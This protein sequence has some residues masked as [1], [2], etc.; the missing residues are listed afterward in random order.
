MTY[1]SVSK[2]LIA[3]FEDDVTCDGCGATIINRNKGDLWF[4]RGAK[5][6]WKSDGLEGVVR[7]LKDADLDND[8]LVNFFENTSSVRVEQRD[9]LRLVCANCGEPIA[10]SD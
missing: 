2:A 7:Y 3:V 4:V 10:S 9:P 6:A 5:E 8:A 1:Y